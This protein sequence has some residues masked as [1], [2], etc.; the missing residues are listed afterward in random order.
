MLKG[1]VMIGHVQLYWKV[2]EEKYPQSEHHE[3]Y[4]DLIEPL[5]QLYSQVI[6]Y[7]ASAICHLSKAQLS[8]AWN[9]VAGSNDW[10]SMAK[11]TEKSSEQCNQIIHLFN[12][13]E[14]EKH[15][16]SQLQKMQES[17]EILNE[18]R[19]ILKDSGTQA[20]R[21]YEDEKEA[22]LLQSFA[23]GYESDKDFNPQRVKDTCEWFF[24]D[25][26]FRKW[27]DSTPQVFS[28]SL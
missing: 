16:K 19:Q 17:Q 10:D 3:D 7:Q 6:E 15:W 21:I 5:A 24:K 18:I 20:Q 4:K 28:G 27:R 25:G 12:D 11:K 22:K 2:Y 14:I 13:G 23:S 26:Q 9:D 1:F 8:R